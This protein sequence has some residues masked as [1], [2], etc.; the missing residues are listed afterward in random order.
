MTVEQIAKKYIDVDKQNEIEE[1]RR[2]QREMVT[3]H[4]QLDALYKRIKSKVPAG[5]P[6]IRD[7]LNDI[8]AAMGNLAEAAY[9]F[10]GRAIQKLSRAIR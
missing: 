7:G 10:L 1:L 8:V 6:T 3:M 9:Q 5:D 4:D 2:F